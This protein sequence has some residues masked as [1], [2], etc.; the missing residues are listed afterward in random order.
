MAYRACTTDVATS[1]RSTSS[2]FARDRRLPPD[3]QLLIHSIRFLS[4]SVI[5]DQ[6]MVASPSTPTLILFRQ[7]LLDKFISRQVFHLE[8]GGETRTIAADVNHSVLLMSQEWAA[9]PKFSTFLVSCNHTWVDFSCKPRIVGMIGS[10]W[11]RSVKWHSRNIRRPVLV[12][13]L[14]SGIAIPRNRVR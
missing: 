8:L 7:V 11:L 9:V 1:T 3:H 5:G 14:C 13:N 4:S 10:T 12:D 6:V 2:E